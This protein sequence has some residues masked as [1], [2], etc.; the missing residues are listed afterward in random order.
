MAS[1]S[2]D[3][4]SEELAHGELVPHL[5]VEYHAEHQIAVDAIAQVVVLVFIFIGR[6]SWSAIII[7]SNTWF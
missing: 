6:L 5:R 2:A 1:F 4:V 7:S 3:F